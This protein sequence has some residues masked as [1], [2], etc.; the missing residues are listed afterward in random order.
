MAADSREGEQ[1]M[2]EQAGIGNIEV[3][4][5]IKGDSA[6][7]ERRADSL[8]QVVVGPGGFLRLLEAQLGIPSRDVSFTARLIQYLGCIDQVNHSGA[9]YH[10]S[11]SADPFSVARTLL[12]WRDQWYLAGWEGT[13]AAEIPARLA[14]MAAIERHAAS[15]VEPGIGQRIQRV[16]ALLPDHPIALGAI[17]LRDELPDFPYLWQQLIQAVNVRLVAAAPAIPKG[18]PGSDLRRLQEHLLQD[19]REKIDLSGDGSVIALRADSPTQ[20]TPL[21]ALLTQSWLRDAPDTTVAVLAQARGELLDD[22][23]EQ[24]HSPRLGFT[25]LSPW[26]PVFQVLPLACELLW[27]PLNP[28]A[29]FQFLSHPV[30]PI[31]ARIR[32]PLARTVADVPG[33]GSAAWEAAV[34]ASLEQED[35]TRR[36][37]V[38]QSLHYWLQSPRFSPQ[39][40]VD[41]E[42]LATRAQRVADWLQGARETS[43]DPA[44]KAL[45]HIA[46]N[47]ALEFVSAIARLKAHGRDPLT[48]DNVRRLIEDVRGTGAPVADRDAEVSASQP[49]VL[50]ADHAGAFAACTVDN[51]IW[52]D[53]Q[54]NDRLQRWPWSRAERAALA[55]GG[56][57]LQT[58][59]AQLAW[60]GKAWLRPLLSARE[61][62]TFVLHDDSERHHPLWD[63]VTSLSRGLPTLQVASSDT[64][65]Q[66]GVASDAVAP[67]SLP[68]RV[69]WWQL[70]A[71]TP[72]PA[73]EAES[74]SSLDAYIHSPYQWL[75]R[76]AARIRPGSLANVIDGNQLKGNLVHRVYEEFFNAHP[77]TASIDT[78]TIDHWVEAHIR[79]LLQQEGA[80]LLEAGRQAECERFITQ[81]Q[82]SLTTLVEHLQSAAVVSVQ[83]ELWQEGRF[84]GGRLNG[85]IDLLAR[86]ADGTEA[87]I[88]IKWGGKKYRRDALLGNSYLQLATYAQ[89]RRDNG[90][91]LPPALSYF[92][93]VD[94]A[95]LSLNHTFFPNADILEPA[96]EEDTARYWQRVENSWRWRRS[97]F[98]RGLVEVTVSDTEPTEQSEPGPDCLELPEASDHFNEYSA[99]TGWGENA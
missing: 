7:P 34:A 68:A 86:R 28:T 40:G 31:P 51:V 89:L 46:L 39:G 36:K 23:L 60:L 79:P 71:S 94:A 49:R 64:A 4:L 42:T 76:Y 97:Q 10:A 12:Q 45:Y 1:T 26:R 91:E 29:L 73:R 56:V 14:D 57:H 78:A 38:E 22:T 6:V 17:T 20:S 65:G 95:L 53:C 27:E 96:E 88:D 72:V 66:L 83:M 41:S 87:V 13:F 59:D 16:M 15:V 43:D 90:A 11:Y 82:D 5:A 84:A 2:G 58:E 33:I 52:W 47:Q 55:T 80:L 81:A 44:R 62:C 77:Q 85:S 63:Q 18:R 99:L 54:A 61:R 35:A 19:S 21:T 70:P 75:L 67:R 9:F 93:V 69:R 98:E 74:Y 92:I 32:E 30:G 50:R 48:R 25:A 3:T 24:L 8:G 37:Q